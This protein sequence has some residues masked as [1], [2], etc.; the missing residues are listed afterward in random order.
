MPKAIEKKRCEYAR[1]GKLFRPARP[2]QKYH[3]TGCKQAAW[4]ARKL[5]TVRRAEKIIKDHAGL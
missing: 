4:W 5:D 2:F 1:C 3:S